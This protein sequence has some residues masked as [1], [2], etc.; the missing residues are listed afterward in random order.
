MVSFAELL[1]ELE[2]VRNVFNL[3]VLLDELGAVLQALLQ[4]LGVILLELRIIALVNLE[5]GTRHVSVG[6]RVLLGLVLLGEAD[7]AEKH[8]LVFLVDEIFEH[9]A[10]LRVLGFDIGRGGKQGQKA[11]AWKRGAG[12][13]SWR[14]R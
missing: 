5:V 8:A 2:L 3:L 12:F 1:D 6:L 4:G 9:P 13:L 11:P 7:G 14:E 10:V